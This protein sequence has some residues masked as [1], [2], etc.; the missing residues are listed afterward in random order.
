[1]PRGAHTVNM[2]CMDSIA[3]PNFLSSLRGGVAA[4]HNLSTPGAPISSKHGECRRSLGLDSTTDLNFS[5]PRSFRTPSAWLHCRGYIL[6]ALGM[7]LSLLRLLSGSQHDISRQRPGTGRNSQRRSAHADSR[8]HAVPTAGNLVMLQGLNNVA[9][10]TLRPE[11]LQ[12]KDVV[13]LSGAKLIKFTFPSM[14]K[15]GYRGD[16]PYSYSWYYRKPGVGG[17]YRRWKEF[18]HP[19]PQGTRGVFYYWLPPIPPPVAAGELRFRVLPPTDQDS[20]EAGIG[21]DGSSLVDLFAQ[22]RDL[23]GPAAKGY[24]WRIWCAPSSPLTT[25]HSIRH[26]VGSCSTRVISVTMYTESFQT[27]GYLP[28]TPRCPDKRIT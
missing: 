26:C 7:P 5:D 23:E 3:I 19:F 10:T 12:A 15:P 28:R 9:I 25:R 18:V 20:A 17:P 13:D 21:T 11:E 27:A 22:G 1:M 6:D 16:R 2:S 14:T 24:P 4:Y 8:R